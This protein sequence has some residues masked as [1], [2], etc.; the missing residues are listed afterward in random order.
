MSNS[1]NKRYGLFSLILFVLR[2]VSQIHSTSPRTDWLQSPLTAKISALLREFERLRDVTGGISWCHKIWWES[3]SLTLNDWVLLD[4]WYRSRCLELSDS[5]ESM[6]PC[7]D[8]V[9]HA[10]DANAYYEQASN[11]DVVLLLRPSGKAQSGEEITISY[12]SSKSSAE[13]LFSY[14][15]VDEGVD[16][17]SLVLDLN[18]LPND[19][20]SKA[21]IAA[22]SGR[23]VVRISSEASTVEWLSPFLYF[24]CVNE[25][26]G[27]EFRVLQQTDG[28]QSQLQVFWQD[29]NVTES[30]ADFE[31][32]VAQHPLKDVF[33][34]RAVC[35]LEDRLQEQL[36][37][38]YATADMSAIIAPSM[39][40][41]DKS[42]FTAASKLRYRETALLEKAF[43]ALDSQVS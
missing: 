19:P 2:R 26:D 13:M 10:R 6:V 16:T 11:G 31:K 18:P 30:T 3:A 39:T 43:K 1:L 22:F 41:M 40:E 32:H 24:I 15:F 5:G 14:G 20:L 23:P 37:R 28:S 33:S 17:E 12:G 27:L 7:L 9:N 35:I 8:I 29:T 36:D 21:K 4:S 25:E 42:L 34:L 38:L